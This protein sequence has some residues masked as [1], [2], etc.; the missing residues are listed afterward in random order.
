MAAGPVRRAAY[1]A[2]SIDLFAVSDLHQRPSAR[3][4]RLSRLFRPR[5]A[6]PG[7]PSGGAAGA[8]VPVR[9]RMC[10]QKVA[11]GG[12]IVARDYRVVRAVQHRFWRAF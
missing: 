8:L 1:R 12:N 3:P 2:A 4:V 5:F 9:T 7:A 11:L 10:S 6:S